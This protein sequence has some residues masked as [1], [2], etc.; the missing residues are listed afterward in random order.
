M[1]Q[2]RVTIVWR[3]DD[4]PLLERTLADLRRP[5]FRKLH[6]RAGAVSP[7]SMALFLEALRK[8]ETTLHTLFLDTPEVM[9]PEGAVALASLFENNVALRKAAIIYRT[10]EETSVA[11]LNGLAKSRSLTVL[12]I[13]RWHL[14][15]LVPQA[16][17][18]MLG[19][20]KSLLQLDI[21]RDEPS[22]HP[23]FYERLAHIVAGSKA[24]VV[25]RMF[26]GER[27]VRA[28]DMRALAPLRWREMALRRAL[29][30]ILTERKYAAAW[31]LF[32]KIEPFQ[33]VGR[34]LQND[35]SWWPGSSM[36]RLEM[37]F[38]SSRSELLPLALIYEC[39]PKGPSRPDPQQ[40][41]EE[42]LGSCLRYVADCF[43]TSLEEWK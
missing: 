43:K 36:S 29:H 21:L 33:L 12:A 31:F 39:I 15:G 40:E 30:A 37:V 19:K 6:I 8:T 38:E 28:F 13:G 35:S 32:D 5:L 17:Q 1:H 4:V 23:A 25:L 22:A 9:K 27:R 24:L 41:F 20:N 3:N 10:T 42:I 14:A 16:F 2:R 11:L 34:F 18:A 26:D 7:D